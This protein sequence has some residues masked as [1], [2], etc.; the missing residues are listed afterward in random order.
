MS[1]SC[2]QTDRSQD[3]TQH[4]LKMSHW[5]HQQERAPK[6]FSLQAHNLDCTTNG[7]LFNCFVFSLSLSFIFSLLWRTCTSMSH[8]ICFVAP[9]R[10]LPCRC[11]GATKKLHQKERNK[12]PKKSPKTHNHCFLR[13]KTFFLLQVRTDAA[14]V[15]D[16]PCQST[17]FPTRVHPVTA[18][19]PSIHTA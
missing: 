16:Q 15:G 4:K 8:N 11:C 6:R 5:S 7:K 17:C 1:H 12:A 9:P 19:E 13:M 18:D 14:M 10:L 3:S 2:M